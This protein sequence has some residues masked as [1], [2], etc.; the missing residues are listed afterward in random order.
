LLGRLMTGDV[1]I[2]WQRPKP[3]ELVI[4]DEM[5]AQFLLD[6]LNPA[7]H[8]LL[9]VRN[10]PVYLHPLIVWRTL[11]GRLTKRHTHHEVVIG[12][13]QPK[14]VVTF[15]DNDPRFHKLASGFPDIRFIAIQ[16]GSRHTFA[17]EAQAFGSPATYNSEFFC[18]GHEVID[19]CK[20]NGYQFKQ[21]KII[22]SLRN[23]LFVQYLQNLAKGF[24][25]SERSDI[26][27]ISQFRRSIEEPSSSQALNEY[28]QV[29][30][31][32]HTYLRSH[33]GLRVSVS[34]VNSI[35]HPD[36]DAE[37]LF[38]QQKLGNLVS[39]IP[40]SADLMSSYLAAEQSNVVVTSTSTLGFE[41]LAR[42]RKTL[43]CDVR[44]SDTFV[45]Q[46][47]TPDWI[48]SRLDQETFDDAITKLSG[49]PLEDF[50]SRNGKSINHFMIAPHEN[51]LSELKKQVLG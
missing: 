51:F 41:S 31:F 8:H 24:H 11:V 27:L 36:H 49:M 9:R 48:L 34:L 5:G 10:C 23:A 32:L 22:G 19:F 46:S 17:D 40:K 3:V 37:R 20:A 44:L 1:E 12:L 4:W 2:L 47:F 30:S 50:V 18:F 45:E 43:M 13:C 29:V 28:K 38:H 15:I 14:A 21:I 25:A 33:P 6:A 26:V 39:L 42:G 35:D 7:S 16:N